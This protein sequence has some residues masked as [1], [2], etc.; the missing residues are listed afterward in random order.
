MVS[1]P[2]EE[3]T[4]SMVI[5]VTKMHR[6]A[7]QRHDEGIQ[8]VD[9]FA[10]F[11]RPIGVPASMFYRYFNGE[12]NA[13][14]SMLQKLPDYSI[15]STYAVTGK[16]VDSLDSDSSP[17]VSTEALRWALNEQ[18]ATYRT[19]GHEALENDANA[20]IARLLDTPNN[21]LAT[22]NRTL[23]V[24]MRLLE[25]VQKKGKRVRS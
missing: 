9:S 20:V 22:A 15:D 13:G 12:Q 23:D 6:A 21:R 18:G 4:F 3:L 14:K 16:R 8:I 25:Q 2:S 1:T 19:W 17:T 24:A 10:A 11:A 7:G 5:D